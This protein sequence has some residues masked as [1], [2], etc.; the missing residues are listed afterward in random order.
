MATRRESQCIIENLPEVQRKKVVDALISG[1][2]LRKV[3][4]M[5]GCSVTAVM[6]YKKRVVKPALRT[7]HQVQHFQAVTSLDSQRFQEHAALTRDI[8]QASPFRERLEK[9]WDRADKALDKAE[10]AVRTRVVDGVEV[11]EEQ[12][13]QA[14]APL[15]NQ[16][17]KNVELLG[18]V[19]GELE[20]AAGSNIAIQ[21][22]L[23]QV[24]AIPSSELAPAYEVID[25][26][27][28]KR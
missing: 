17:H 26:A 24:A 9:L 19:T 12:G 25:I 3:G 13:L 8:V 11:W 4:E 28:P 22:V 5:A 10:N 18:R 20:V 23:P 6:A 1:V 21:I 2:S 14:I 15:L 16:A 27:P 7:A